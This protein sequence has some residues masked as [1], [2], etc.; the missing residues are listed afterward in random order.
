MQKC[1]HVPFPLQAE[2]R[3]SSFHVKQRKREVTICRLVEYQPLFN[4]GGGGSYINVIG[5]IV[6]NCEKNKIKGTRILFC[7]HIINNF[8]PL[9]GT[10]SF[11]S[12]HIFRLNPIKGTVKAL[13]PGSHFR[14]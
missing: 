3:V 10:K 6:G 9:R 14:F 2:R 12:R 5:A 13:T 11:T 7:G 4:L 8:L 1:R